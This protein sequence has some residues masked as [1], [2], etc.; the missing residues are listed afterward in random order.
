MVADVLWVVYV[1]L[2]MSVLGE[3]DRTSTRQ[4]VLT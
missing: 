1:F 2:S 3:R 4:E